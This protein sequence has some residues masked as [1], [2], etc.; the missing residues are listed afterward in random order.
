LIDDF[1]EGALA[2]RPRSALTAA[3]VPIP[4]NRRP[5]R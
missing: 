3:G 5:R 1:D 2:A 4:S